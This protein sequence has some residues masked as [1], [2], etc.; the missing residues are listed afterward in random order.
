MAMKAA[1]LAVLVIAAERP[2]LAETVYEL[3]AATSVGATDNASA[4][5]TGEARVRDGFGI[6]TVGGRARH[7]GARST[8]VV[9]LQLVRTQFLTDSE[10]DSTSGN[11][12][13]ASEMNLTA[14]WDLRLGANALLSRT[15][16]VTSG[17]P[18]VA[19]PQGVLAAPLTFLNTGVTE[20]LSYT[21]NP[22]LAYAESLAFGQV[23]YL[24]DAIDAPTNTVVT[25][26]LRVDWSLARDTLSAEGT[27]TDSYMPRPA[28]GAT[29]VFSQGNVFL[30]QLLAGWRR[31]LS[32]RWSAELHAGALE[33]F[34]LDGHAVIAPSGRGVL[35]F[36]RVPWFATLIVSQLPVA[37]LYLGQATVSDQALARLSLPLTSR[38]LVVVSGFGGFTS[39][40]LVDSQGHLARAYDQWS[41]G[42]SLTARFAR[43][44]FAGALEY[45]F[46]DQNGDS[47]SAGAIPSLVR[48]TVMLVFGG[49][50]LWGPGTPSLLRGGL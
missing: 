35:E 45:T 36:R 2:S 49:T 11:F 13:G 9:G 32:V 29:G 28:P 31:E 41:V 33:L 39:A 38:E 47:G 24:N 10:A 15:T 1:M 23:R 3:A 8:D 27:L 34:N 6:A 5:P 46:I 12:V 7:R 42:T 30:A 16:G 40:R 50:F 19:M 4:S 44:P 37:N 48:Q 43:L 17:S 25:G 18:D 26:Q 14:A 22:R 21:P 20:N